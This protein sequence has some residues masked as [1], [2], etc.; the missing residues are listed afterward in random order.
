MIRTA[1][2]MVRLATI[3]WQFMPFVMAM[4]QLADEMKHLSG[5]ERRELVA[6][7]LAAAQAQ[8]AGMRDDE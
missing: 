2:K 7:V 1:N 8:I 4:V 5:E 3:A 6:G